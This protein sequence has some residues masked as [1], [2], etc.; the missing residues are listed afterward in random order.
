VRPI[1]ERAGAEEDNGR[2]RTLRCCNGLEATRSD[3]GASL[4]DEL[5]TKHSIV[6]ESGAR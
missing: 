6:V 2:E 4:R 5:R 1:Y 3:F